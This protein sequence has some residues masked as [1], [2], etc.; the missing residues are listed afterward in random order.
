MKRI[1]AALQ[2]SSGMDLADNL[3]QAR[4]LLEQAAGQGAVMAVLPEMFPLLGQGED[5]TRAKNL[6][7][8]SEGQGLIQDFL[9]EQAQQLKLWIIGGT[10]PL[11]SQDPQRPFAS[12]LVI[13]PEGKIAARYDKMHLFDVVISETESYLE[14]GSTTPGQKTVLLDTP[15]GKMGLSVCFDIRF[16]EL[17]RELYAQGAELFVVPSAF[18][19]PTGIAHW[20][21][22]LRARAIENYAYLI[23]AAQVGTHGQGRKT[24]GHSMIIDPTGKIIASLEAGPGIILSEIDPALIRLQRQ[25]MGQ[26]R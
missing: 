18:T 16:P 1:I 6:L 12:S 19:V 14:S 2:L 7:Q 10:L 11:K 22:L 25:K 9:F 5:F 24:Y 20:E 4:N 21:V 3:A 26:N 17:Y 8:E 23:A 13:T 15:C